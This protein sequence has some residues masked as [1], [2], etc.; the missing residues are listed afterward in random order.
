MEVE[1]KKKIERVPEYDKS[2]TQTTFQW[3]E[4]SDDPKRPC[5][6]A[7]HHAPST[8]FTPLPQPH[9]NP[10]LHPHETHSP[11]LAAHSITKNAV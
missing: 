10:H 4:K 6:C 2:R 7:H 9:P 1:E 5:T 3:H 11:L 8:F